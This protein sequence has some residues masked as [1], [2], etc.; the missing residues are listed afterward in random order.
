MKYYVIQELF[1]LDNNDIPSDH[2]A[3]LEFYEKW[4]PKVMD[5]HHSPKAAKIGKKVKRNGS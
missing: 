2:E 3:I 5:F 1:P 4:Y